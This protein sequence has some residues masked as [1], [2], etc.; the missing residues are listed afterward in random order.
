LKIR[1]NNEHYLSTDEFSLENEFCNLE[2]KVKQ[3]ITEL[4]FCVLEFEEHGG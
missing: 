3:I 2:T 4:A 1:I